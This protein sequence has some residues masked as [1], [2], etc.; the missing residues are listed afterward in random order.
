MLTR[1]T[2]PIIRKVPNNNLARIT[3][4]LSTESKGS[5]SAIPSRDQQR[6]LN[7]VHQLQERNENRILKPLELYIYSYQKLEV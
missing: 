5:N 4:A 2:T 1:R 3:E 7:S 6:C